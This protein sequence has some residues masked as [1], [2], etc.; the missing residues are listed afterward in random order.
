MK[1]TDKKIRSLS[2]REKSFKLFDGGGLFIFI[3]PKGSRLW[4]YKYRFAG[5]E[6]LL[7]IG[8][9]PDISLA[10]ARRIHLKAR[11]LLARGLDPAEQKRQDKKSAQAA[12]RNNLNFLV[13]EW[14]VTHSRRVVPERAR[15]LKSALTRHCLPYLGHHPLQSLQPPIV[16]EWLHRLETK[17]GSATVHLCK[18]ALKMALD[19]AV[20]R[21][22]L[23]QNPLDQRGIS[24]QIAPH[25]VRHHPA[26]Q[27]PIDVAPILRALDGLP[28]RWSIQTRCALRLLPLIATR[29]S[30]ML[31]MKWMDVDWEK[32]EWRFTA[33]KTKTP[34]V[35]PLSRQAISILRELW[36]RTGKSTHAFANGRTP[37]K[38]IH[39]KWLPRAMSNIPGIAAGSIVPHGWRAV[40]STLGQE[41][42][43]FHLTWIELQLGH[44][45]RGPLG[46]TY[47][48][49]SF[50]EQRRQ[51][52]QRWADYLDELKATGGIS[53]GIETPRMA[54]APCPE[55]RSCV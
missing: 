40:F 3:T 29:P 6:R 33:S 8:K 10:E 31:H 34:I 47:N 41:S 45:I 18:S 32:R 1:L 7:V 37:G 14:I 13:S 42:C 15:A 54:A 35:V 52:M 44:R 25:R 9:Y 11:G 53:R 39:S 48:R 38:P 30:E 4:R 26:P 28:P 12:V 24:R 2:P 46:D 50:L 22:M 43:G 19:F 49:A 23:D 20:A 5:R 55:D 51:M 27:N 17:V 16:L 21:G 36:A